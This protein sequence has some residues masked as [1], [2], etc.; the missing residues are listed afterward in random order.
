M[1]TNEGV[2]WISEL[3]GLLATE[4]NLLLSQHAK[5]LELQ[6]LP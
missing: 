4:V 1:V 5:K 2:G 3:T 6:H